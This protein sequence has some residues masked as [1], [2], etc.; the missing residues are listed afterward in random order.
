MTIAMVAVV[1]LLL[2]GPERVSGVTEPGAG[3]VP[4]PIIPKG[5]GEACVADTAFMRRNHM[6]MLRHQRDETMRQG[7]RGNAYSLEA[8]IACHTVAGPDAQP[9]SV[10]DPEHF[11]RACH[12]YAAVSIDCFQCHA[13][14]PEPA[15]VA[16][17]PGRT[18]GAAAA[19]V[20]QE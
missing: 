9:L 18:G 6:S 12:D 16:D 17:G 15:V 2:A 5:Q 4:L 20:A 11:C 13:S 8:C 3:G 10:D 1:V 19:G 7:I 14:R